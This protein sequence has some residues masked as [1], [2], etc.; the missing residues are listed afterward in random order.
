MEHIFSGAFVGYIQTLHREPD[1][2]RWDLRESIFA[3]GELLEMKLRNPRWI[4]GLSEAQNQEFYENGTV[5][6]W[7]PDPLV[8]YHS[9]LRL[10]YS[11]PADWCLFLPHWLLL[12]TVAIPWSALL[13]WRAK[14]GPEL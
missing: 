11:T 6:G 1:A 9:A 5:G 10:K 3:P 12:L 4:K 8:Y 14:R 7:I 13:L 2:E